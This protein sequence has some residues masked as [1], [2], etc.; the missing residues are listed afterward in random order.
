MDDLT[1]FR[2]LALALGVGLLIGVERGWRMR[3]EAAGHRVAGIRTFAILGLLGGV[4]GLVGTRLGAAAPAVG[5]L[6]VVAVLA[7]GYRASLK[8]DTDNISATNSLVAIFTLFLGM[9][10][11]LGFDII[12]VAAAGVAMLVLAMREQLHGWLKRLEDSDIQATARYAIIALVI[13]P[14]LPDHAYGPYGAW[15]PRQLWLVVALVTGL[16][17]AGYIASKKLGAARG[18]IAAAAIAATVSSTAV[19]SELSRRLRNPAEEPTI[20]R[21]GIAAASAV[22]FL[23]VL[24]LTALLATPALSMFALAIGGATVVAVSWGIVLARRAD[25]L[26]GKALPVRNPFEVL[27]AIGFAAIVG[28]M[29][30]ASRWAIERF[31]DAGLAML[32]G[33]IGLYDVDSAIITVGNL[34]AGVVT[35]DKAGLLLVLPIIVNSLV[36][37]LIALVFAGPKRGWP[38]S[39]PLFAAAGVSAAGMAAAWMTIS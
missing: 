5:S 16:S 33:L 34:P 36:K 22:M 12:A 20:L 10:A 31:G 26:A 9:L 19:I 8:L 15:N 21:A 28:L 17:F 23:R 38:A 7:L 1:P 14:I 35:P 6:G 13:L 2:G 18:T 25:G 24:V 11:A 39:I 30:L 3:G 37:A 29:V 4:L 32:L 27:P